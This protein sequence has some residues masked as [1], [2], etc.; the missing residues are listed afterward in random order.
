MHCDAS[1]LA[2]L[3]GRFSLR[4]EIDTGHDRERCDTEHNKEERRIAAATRPRDAGC[5]C[6]G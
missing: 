4:S 3:P 5:R 1:A 2:S 6:L